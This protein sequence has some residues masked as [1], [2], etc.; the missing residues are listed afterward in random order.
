MQDLLLVGKIVNTF[1][2]KGEMKIY[3]SY[4]FFDK[5]TSLIIKDKEY[6]VEKIRFQ[7]NLYVVKVKGIDDI[8]IV[9]TLKNVE[10]YVE[11]SKAPKLPENTYYIQDIL[12]FEVITDEGKVLGTLD[13]V[14]NT[15]ANDIYQIGEILLPATEE[16]IKKIDLENKQI[17][18]HILKGMI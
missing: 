5:L 7:K 18:V 14:F 11:K 15:G 17:I 9:E 16:V 12:G 13:D 4:E 2:I 8:S 3:P 6:E 10:V 1:G